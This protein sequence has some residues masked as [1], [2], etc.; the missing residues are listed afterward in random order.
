M[1]RPARKHAEIIEEIGAAF[2]EA[3]QRV[4]RC[5]YSPYP[6]S[7]MSAELFKLPRIICIRRMGWNEWE[8]IPHVTPPW[9]RKVLRAFF[10]E[11][12]RVAFADLAD[13]GRALQ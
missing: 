10:G 13:A 3:T 1:H 5:R 4:G 8:L 2:A 12:R 9:F 11:L 7:S 6:S